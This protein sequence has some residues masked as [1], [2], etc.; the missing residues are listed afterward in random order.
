MTINVGSVIGPRR[1]VRPSLFGRAKLIALRPILDT[2]DRY[3]VGLTQNPVD[4]PTD[5]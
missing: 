4:Q 2:G 5:Q 1:S 3:I